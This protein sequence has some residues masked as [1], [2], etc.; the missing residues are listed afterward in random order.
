MPIAFKHA[1]RTLAITCAVLA[2]LPAAFAQQ[3]PG[4]ALPPPSLYDDVPPV[5]GPA[6]LPARPAAPLQAEPAPASTEQPA[7]AAASVESKPMT[8][9]PSNASAK[10]P[11]YKRLWPF[12]GNG[13]K[14]GQKQAQA[15][16]AAA[17]A[18]GRGGVESA[19]LASDRF[20][21][22]LRTGM[23]GDC[24]KMG[25]SGGEC[26]SAPTPAAEPAAVAAVAPPAARVEEPRPAQLE[27]AP[28]QPAPEPRALEP[29]TVPPP[30]T[31]APEPPP[32]PP[33][34]PMTKTTT[35]AADALFDFGSAELKPVAKAKLDQLAVQLDQFDY[36]RIL[37]T[38]HTDPTGP[39]EVN[40]RLSLQRAESVKRYLVSK[41]LSAEKIEAEGMGSS[42]PMVTDKD[43]S[44]LSRGQKIACYQLD[45]RVE[46][47]VTGVTLA[48]K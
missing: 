4:P 37:I 20:S 24:V 38:G 40:E 11:W 44:K 21:R 9:A 28:S 48:N 31:A 1:F 7:P 14:N 41:G 30:V 45:R 46:I 12:G 33:P 23:L 27:P 34:A 29:D 22:G 39:S 42:M 13:R 43:C 25:T 10:Q 17:P 18:G 3:G 19:E 47:E 36:Q 5:P 16:A 2:V 35:L 6:T 32:P 8:A 26:P 15:P